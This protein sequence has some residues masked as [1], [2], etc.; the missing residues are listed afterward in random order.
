MPSVTVQF[1]LRVSALLLALCLVCMPLC[2]ARCAVQACAAPLTS[3]STGSTG[4]ACHHRAG[5]QSHTGLKTFAIGTPCPVSENIAAL[6]R[7]GSPVLH[8]DLGLHSATAAVSRGTQ[9]SLSSIAG[10]LAVSSSASP[11][12]INF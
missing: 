12:G 7:N 3:T 2:S 4:D 10:M 8:S 9:V 11:H 1:A 6:W 5:V